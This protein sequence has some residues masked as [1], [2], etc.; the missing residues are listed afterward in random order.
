MAAPHVAGAWALL[1]QKKP[2]ITVTEALTALSSTGVSVTDTRNGV[3]KPRINI[4]AALASVVATALPSAPTIGTAVS[5]NSSISVNFTPGSIGSGT[6]VQYWAGC[7]A[8]NVNILYGTGNS[9]PVV[10]PSLTN[11]LTYLCYA[12]AE[13]TLGYGAWSTGSN[14]VVVGLAGAPTSVSTA[15][16]PGGIRVSFVAPVNTGA[17]ITGYTATCSASG[18]TTKTATGSTSPI[19]VGGLTFGVTYSCTVT[20]N[21]AYGSSS[22]SSVATASPGKTVDLTPILMLLLD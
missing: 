17:G 16:A 21:T 15:A 22:A 10:V 9:P 20:A 19:T 14:A 1:K 4:N 12:L 6:L 18:Q 7:S 8:D 5:G 11:G 13:S 2:N 3:T